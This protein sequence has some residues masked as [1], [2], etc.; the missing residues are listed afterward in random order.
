M[1]LAT[2]LAVMIMACRTKEELSVARGKVQ[3]AFDKDP[4]WKK[5][6][7]EWLI[8]IRDSKTWELGLPDKPFEDTLNTRGKRALK[9]GTLEKP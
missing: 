9:K 8:D 1:H 3:A 4:A 5:D 7:K 2:D 6:W